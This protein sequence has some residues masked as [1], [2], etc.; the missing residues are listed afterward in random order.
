LSGDGNGA[1][2]SQCGPSM[3]RHV[4]QAAMEN[5]PGFAACTFHTR[6]LPFVPRRGW[7][8]NH[9]ASASRGSSAC[10]TLHWA[11]RAVSG[12]HVPSSQPVENNV[13]VVS[14]TRPQTAWLPGRFPA[15]SGV[16]SKRWARQPHLGASQSVLER[17][18]PVPTSWSRCRQQETTEDTVHSLALKSIPHC[19]MVPPEMERLRQNGTAWQILKQ[20]APTSPVDRAPP[21]PVPK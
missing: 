7:P 10:L 1:P 8:S 11:I 14:T 19:V 12:H 15:F 13:S 5:G 2:C 3:L 4:C 6:H 9:N 20:T 16:W 21:P 17:D 18:K